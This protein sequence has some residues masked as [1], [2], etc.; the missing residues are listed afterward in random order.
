MSDLSVNVPSVYIHG[1][2]IIETA[3]FS[4]IMQLY[5]HVS[6]NLKAGYYKEFQFTKSMNL[7]IK[8][9]KCACLE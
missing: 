4:R 8:Y 9:L 2:V 7:F 3:A 5:M 6:V 1:A